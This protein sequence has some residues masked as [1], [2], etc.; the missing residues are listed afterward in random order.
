MNRVKQ[1][2]EEARNLGMKIRF[3]IED[4]SR[5]NGED[6]SYLGK[7]AYQA[8]ASRISLADTVGI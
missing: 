3:T 4:A 5:T 2:I 8:G 6:I 7:I 1:A